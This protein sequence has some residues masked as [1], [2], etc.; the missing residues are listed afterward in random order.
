VAYYK[1]VPTEELKKY[2]RA[3]IELTYGHNHTVETKCSVIFSQK[4]MLVAR[5]QEPPYPMAGWS[6]KMAAYGVYTFLGPCVCKCVCVRACVNVYACS[7]MLVIPQIII[8]AFY[9]YTQVRK[10]NSTA[11]T[12]LCDK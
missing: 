7:C 5:I 3:L 8:I 2:I 9:A 1:Y 10:N 4:V 12:Y 6:K 11:H